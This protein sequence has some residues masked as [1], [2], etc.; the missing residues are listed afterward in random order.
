MFRYVKE[1]A[2]AL[3]PSSLLESI[4]LVSEDDFLSTH[5]TNKQQ[6]PPAHRRNKDSRSLASRAVAR[7]LRAT[8]Q[9]SSTEAVLLQHS[10]D[11]E[12]SPQQYGVPDPSKPSLDFPYEILMH[13]FQYLP[14]SD[15]FS[16]VA[17]NRLWRQIAFLETKQI[18]ISEC[19]PL[20]C[21]GLED[22]TYSDFDFVYNLFSMFP[23]ISCLIVKDRYMRD[24][25]M[26]VVTAGILAGKMAFTKATGPAVGSEAYRSAQHAIAER[27]RRQRGEDNE[28][29]SEKGTFEWIDTSSITSPV[30]ARPTAKLMLGT[31][32]EEL[33]GFS[34]SVGGYV[35][36]PRTWKTLRKKI[37]ERLEHNLEQKEIQEYLW[38]LE[39]GFDPETFCPST[40]ASLLSS[41]TSAVAA[42]SKRHPLVPMT[43]YRF[44]DC[45]FAKDW[46]ASMDNNKLPMIGLAAVISGQ[47]LVVDMEGSYGA[48][49]KSINV[50]L[51]FCFGPGCVISLDL[52]FRHTH[53]ELEHVTAMLS[54]NPVLYKIDIVDSPAYHDLLRLPALRGLGDIMERMQEAC[55]DL[56]E[57]ALEASLRQARL[58]L[59]DLEK[60]IELEERNQE[61]KDASTQIDPGSSTEDPAIPG[62]YTIGI[63]SQPTNDPDA[64]IKSLSRQLEFP[65][66]V[67]ETDKIRTAKVLLK[68]V[69]HHGI[70]G[71]VNTRHR[72]FGQSLL[73]TL[74]WRKSYAPLVAHAMR[75]SMS[76]KTVCLPTPP[77]HEP[78][79]QGLDP[80]T[81]SLFA[82]SYPPSTMPSISG[83]G[84][85]SSLPS[86]LHGSVTDAAQ[87]SSLSRMGDKPPATSSRLSSLI[88]VSAL[89]A[90][91]SSALSFRRLSLPSTLWIPEDSEDVGYGGGSLPTPDQEGDYCYMEEEGDP[92]GDDD[93]DDLDKDDDSDLG[94]EITGTEDVSTTSGEEEL[95]A[96]SAPPS[97]SPSPS[98]SPP[99]NTASL[100]QAPVVLI[101]EQHPAA[102]ALRMAKILLQLE[103]D[104]NVYNQDGRS[105]VL[106]ASYMG[107]Q[108]MEAL[109]IEHGGYMKELVRIRES[110]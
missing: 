25:D 50:V 85:P 7:G 99:S 78:Q 11:S 31:I 79:H 89:P 69:L 16:V 41:S 13:I 103:A 68:G 49:S 29:P 28:Q 47:G 108:P 10:D 82:S 73:H 65:L 93:E 94:L 4:R 33:R 19:F 38:V 57:T 34:R 64:P 106:C 62:P 9:S 59:L 58:L 56:D 86:A 51:G 100:A 1:G 66:H 74:A 8:H 92:Y 42:E 87:G 48:P 53:M 101:P 110:M 6:R 20:D 30:I 107:F 12:L 44:L 39:N 91:L 22:Q 60:A 40:A 80:A 61:K 21:L 67:L 88:S 105:A 104:P 14:A 81:E 72:R 83:P 90:A 43:H 96:V 27:R 36:T 35:L 63:S 71:L 17:V 5:A 37:L 76:K 46:G 98:P 55:L 70:V 23:L 52:N 24:R 3:M 32:Q 84:F 109:L 102:I 15:L 2:L 54:G 18:D 95:L 75:S 26:R 97:P 77:P 45:C